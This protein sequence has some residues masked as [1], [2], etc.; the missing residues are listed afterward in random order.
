MRSTEPP[1][2]SITG[3]SSRSVPRISDESRENVL[4][5]ASS[6]QAER[7]ADRDEE[8]REREVGDIAG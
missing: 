7:E 5:T 6:A 1:A 4:A 2:L 3:S 8:D